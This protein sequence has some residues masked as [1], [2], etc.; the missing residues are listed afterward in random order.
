M[1][2]SLTSGTLSFGSYLLNIDFKLPEKLSRG[3]FYSPLSLPLPL[4]PEPKRMQATS[5]LPVCRCPFNGAMFCNRL[6]NALKELN[7][8]DFNSDVHSSEPACNCGW[9]LVCI[10]WSRQSFIQ[11]FYIIFFSNMSL[12]NISFHYVITHFIVFVDLKAHSGADETSNTNSLL[13][14]TSM[15]AYVILLYFCNQH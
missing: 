14:N 9:C 7:L 6:A 15:C 3:V 5:K 8:Q 10:L 12:V 1:K 2:I 11:Q 13:L 4:P